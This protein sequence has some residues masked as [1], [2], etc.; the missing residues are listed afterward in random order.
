MFKKTSVLA[1]LI[2]I[3]IQGCVKELVKDSSPISTFEVFWQT[4]NER[5]VYFEEKHINWDSVYTVYR[6]K[7]N[8][9]TSESELILTLRKILTLINDGHL[10]IQIEDN[11]Y[12]RSDSL[13]K[14][15]CFNELRG[16][17]Y[18]FPSF[19]NF[20][21]PLCSQQF[22]NHIS[23]LNVSSFYSDLSLDSVKRLIG[24]KVYNNG[25]VLDLRGNGGGYEKK[26]CELLSLFSPP[27]FLAGFE[28]I[29]TGPDRSSFSGYNEFFIQG[30]SYV[31]LE[32]HKVI[33]MDSNVYSAGNIFCAFMKEIPN[34]TII[35]THS[36]G[37]GGSPLSVMLPNNWILTLPQNK[38]FNL[39]YQSLEKGVSPD[40][41]LYVPKKYWDTIT[42]TSAPDPV[43]ERALQYLY[44]RK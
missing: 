17:H 29:K 33:L 38:L 23:Y 5:Y 6:P 24:S 40:I 14:F 7:I 35:G 27:N 10:A 31:P 21:K 32:I 36:S 43:I 34:T 39:D 25:F 3:I 2:V 8:S 18:Y 30:S 11:K 26:M 19:T 37:G 28:Q 13:P 42:R 15:L 16:L 41:P 44:S 20:T 9:S 12:I 22:D 4:L 1:I